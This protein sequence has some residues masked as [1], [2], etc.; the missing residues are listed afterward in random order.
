MTR[1][2][3]THLNDLSFSGLFIDYS[4]LLSFKTLKLK[5]IYFIT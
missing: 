5:K 3:V 4:D 2:E 1:D